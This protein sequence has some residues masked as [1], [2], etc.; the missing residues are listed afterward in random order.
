VPY[1]KPQRYSVRHRITGGIAAL[2]GLDK[3]LPEFP[4]TD[5]VASEIL[6]TYILTNDGLEIHCS[7]I[8]RFPT[9]LRSLGLAGVPMEIGRAHV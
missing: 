6:G 2:M 9:R 7:T 8:F 1:V 3:I 4:H 5:T